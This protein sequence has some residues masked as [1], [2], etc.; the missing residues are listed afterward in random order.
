MD[1]RS[2]AVGTKRLRLPKPAGVS[3][4]RISKAADSAI[5]GAR[6]G[7]RGLKVCMTLKWTSVAVGSLVTLVTTG[8]GTQVEGL[9]LQEWIRGGPSA[10]GGQDETSSTAPGDAGSDAREPGPADGAAGEVDS[11]LVANEAGDA[12]GQPDAG[13]GFRWKVEVLATV[14]S[15]SSLY[16]PRLAVSASGNMVVGWSESDRA[17]VETLW[18]SRRTVVDNEWKV[19]RAASGGRLVPPSL[20]AIAVGGDDGAVLFKPVV[21]KVIRFGISAPLEAPFDYLEP[22]EGDLVVD[23]QN[24][25]TVLHGSSKLTASRYA[26]GLPSDDVDLAQRT[27]PEAW[28]L[29]LSANRSGQLLASW[30]ERVGDEGHIAVARFSED[31]WGPVVD[32]STSEGL[33]SRN[34]RA[35]LDATGRAVV[36]WQAVAGDGSS[37]IHAAIFAPGGDWSAPLQ[38]SGEGTATAVDVG[39]AGEEA[40]AV[41][42]ETGGAATYGAIAASI[43]VPGTGWSGP[44]WVSDPTARGVDARLVVTP[45]GDCIVVWQEDSPSSATETSSIWAARRRAGE[46]WDVPFRLSDPAYGS[47][48]E[49]RIATDASGHVV[50]VWVQ[51]QNVMV[52]SLE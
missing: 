7:K 27:V 43:F 1:R 25:L 34:P 38:V 33:F 29:V 9:H 36:A 49:P 51:G 13:D 4:H 20:V 47:S 45:S 37:Q 30:H 40:T 21:L 12:G 39:I 10:G 32:L 44:T 26:R 16:H 48:K 17:Y 3:L 6:I 50:S 35:A 2:G 31:G 11:P 22:Q 41:W 5:A 15:D 52:A 24:V 23:D 28:D 18:L 8:C 42:Q 14:P 19:E 46:R